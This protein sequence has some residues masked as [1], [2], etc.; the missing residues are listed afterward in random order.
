MMKKRLITILT[1]VMS[2]ALFALATGCG[3]NP[4]STSE[5]P[6][7]ESVS[8][9]AEISVTLDKKDLTVDMYDEGILT[10]TVKNSDETVVWTSDNEKIATVSEG[11]VKGVAVGET[12]VKATVGEKTAV[13]NV[14]V[15]K[16]SELPVIRTEYSEMNLYSGDV[17]DFEVYTKWK[18]KTIDASYEWSVK[19]GNDVLTVENGT[20]NGI[21]TLNAL[22]AGIAEYTV[23]ATAVGST[24]YADVKF[25]VTNPDYALI[26]ANFDKTENGYEYLL[27]RK[28][29]AETS[30]KAEVT[31]T[32]A[33]KEIDYAEI[34]WVSSAT[35]V[36][37]V[38]NGVITGKKDGKA[39][40]TATVSGRGIEPFETTVELTVKEEIYR[41]VTYYDSDKST[42]LFEEDV[43][44]GT[45][46]KYVNDEYPD[47]FDLGDGYTGHYNVCEWVTENG[48]NASS[49]LKG[50]TEDITVYAAYGYI[51]YKHYEFNAAASDH[52]VFNGAFASHNKYA[53]IENGKLEMSF[54]VYADNTQVA[55]MELNNWLTPLVLDCKKD[56]WY[57]FV[58]E[59]ENDETGAH[60]YVGVK[61]YV[62]DESG[63]VVKQATASDY[64]ERLWVF[65]KMPYTTDA[66]GNAIYASECKIDVGVPQSGIKTTHTVRYLDEDDNELYTEEVADGGASS[67]EYGA[68][69][70]QD[71]V[72]GNGYTLSYGGYK[73]V[74]EKGGKIEA[75]LD[76]IAGDVSVYLKKIYVAYNTV[77]K[78]NFLSIT[79]ANKY[80]YA[81]N[82]QLSFKLRVTSGKVDETTLSI[83]E[84]TSWKAEYDESRIALWFNNIG[85]N[86]WVTVTIDSNAKTYV[87]FD[88]ESYKTET[89]KFGE[90]N[91]DN[92]SLVA[93]QFTIELAAIEPKLKPTFDV[94]YYDTDGTTVLYVEKVEEGDKA[95]YV[96]GKDLGDGYAETYFNVK[97]LT[98]AGGGT[99][100]ELSSVTENKSVYLSGEK[101]IVKSYEYSKQDANGSGLLNSPEKIHKYA[102]VKN[103]K[104]DFY[105]RP[106]QA[107]SKIAFMEIVNWSTPFNSYLPNANEWYHVVAEFDE[108][109]NGIKVSIYDSNGGV[110]ADAISITSCTTS[111][112]WLIV[113]TEIT[114][115]NTPAFAESGACDLAFKA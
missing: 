90:V 105:I 68:E 106:H 110:V 72:L 75:D 16:F 55:F 78:P 84:N 30:V 32:R 102:A 73:W 3:N 81:E 34:T 46:A 59:F 67:F 58:I 47:D 92:I 54:R 82:G 112:L 98:Q 43:L 71:Q 5:K 62:L 17:F 37:T 22:K 49:A 74:T 50:V 97:W 2:V 4:N 44:D 70:E 26:I 111:N 79:A 89:L 41:K 36:A 83:Y 63:K 6:D 18:G 42:V 25:I 27:W 107:Y 61:A 24:V 9:A 109:G 104:L 23:S 53:K 114:D 76:N 80:I 19:S 1:V 31:V 60:Q 20:E 38:E 39:T 86:K 10:A 51:A 85:L 14:S 64:D 7:S 11:V 21:F 12:V 8:P 113:S 45:A 91:F 15:T 108:S 95:T 115:W 77:D 69:G 96:P 94:T 101:Y 66:D 103:G 48:R 100:A 33:G 56:V 40:I 57:T 87:V 99:E 65:A 35:D 88:G 13:C 29:N 52:T 28:A 93:S